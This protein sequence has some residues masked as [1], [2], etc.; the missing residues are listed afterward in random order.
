M[1]DN[2]DSSFRAIPTAIKHRALLEST[3]CVRSILMPGSQRNLGS[4]NPL[5]LTGLGIYLNIFK[6]VSLKPIGHFSPAVMWPW[7]HHSAFRGSFLLLNELNQIM[8]YSCK[9]LPPPKEKEFKAFSSAKHRVSNEVDKDRWFLWQFC[10]P[11]VPSDSQH[12]TLEESFPRW[13]WWHR[14]SFLWPH[15]NAA[16]PGDACWWQFEVLC[17]LR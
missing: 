6:N 13:K 14:N 3:G 7:G 12:L 11:A 17:T 4:D 16:D 8:F 1:L 5:N 2:C 15:S 10:L 9:R